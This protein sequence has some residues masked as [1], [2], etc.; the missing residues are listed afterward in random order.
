MTKA[1][2]EKAATPK[3]SP[4]VRSGTVA[5]E[6][7]KARAGTASTADKSVKTPAARNEQKTAGAAGTTGAKTGAQAQAG[8]RTPS[9]SV[10][11]TT[12]TTGQTAGRPTGTTATHPNS[13]V[14]AK[15]NRPA[16]QNAHN[17]ASAGKLADKNATIP[18]GA[19]QHK[20]TLGGKTDIVKTGGTI[21]GSVKNS[22]GQEVK[23][24][25]QNSKGT[26]YTNTK[27]GVATHI[28][29]KGNRITT[30]NTKTGVSTIKTP[31]RKEVVKT[32]PKTGKVVS[33]DIT[34]RGGTHV[35]INNNGTRTVT[36]VNNVSVTYGSRYAVGRAN[37][38]PRT[39]VYGGGYSYH[40]NY[41]GYYGG[42]W[43]WG[44][45]TWVPCYNPWVFGFG[46]YASPLYAG[47][48]VYNPWVNP[49]AF[50]GYPTY[51]V[52]H[53]WWSLWYNLTTPLYQPYSYYY[54]AGYPS[55]D[56]YMSDL[57]FDYSLS[58]LEARR[59]RIRAEREA[60]RARIAALTEQEREEQAEEIQADQDLQAQ[61]DELA[62]NDAAATEDGQVDPQLRDQIRTEV[63]TALQQSQQ[64]NVTPNTQPTTD[65]PAT[66]DSNPVA[67]EQILTSHPN[68]VF[69]VNIGTDQ[70][71]STQNTG[72]DAD[73][74]DSDSNSNGDTIEAQTLNHKDPKTGDILS[75]QLGVGDYITIADQN[76]VASIDKDTKEIQM[77]V[78]K[79][80]KGSC[81]KGEV[82]L[83][84]TKDLQKMINEFYASLVPLADKAKAQNPP[85]EVKQGGQQVT[86]N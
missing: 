9:P 7:P 18:E 58:Y 19:S 48:Y 25:T 61:Q 69:E 63:A 73:G 14:A 80:N 59:E 33:H 22:S 54:T 5:A 21:K 78:R 23:T 53:P 30:T 11:T 76:S 55:L 15:G 32:D 6:A 84:E 77:V 56:Y 24:F 38:Y 68:F 72:T 36:R 82:V 34:Y 8:T 28:S 65:A 1:A 75:C 85:T 67:L 60:E 12:K 42:R 71:A 49:W 13:V 50:G 40:Y 39:V 3:T 17:T 66:A 81:K 27:T 43:G 20:N 79:S 64:A 52:G 16:A 46:F 45:N 10:R 51:W 70:A 35:T 4:S 41:V 26:T 29:P 83:V 31:T 2:P 57:Y 62:S 44:F 74:D 37:Y 47:Y 86:R